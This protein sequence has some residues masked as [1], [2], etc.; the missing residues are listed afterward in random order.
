MGFNTKNRR[1]NSGMVVPNLDK[2]PAWGACLAKT[3]ADMAEGDDD[4][5]PD[6]IVVSCLTFD[7]RGVKGIDVNRRP[8]ASKCLR[9]G[10][11]MG[12]LDP[13]LTSVDCRRE[14]VVAFRTSMLCSSMFR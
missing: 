2:Y 11:G 1:L 6:G 12:V 7:T 3:H 4:D 14:G 9:V 5:G 8:L 13:S 10:V